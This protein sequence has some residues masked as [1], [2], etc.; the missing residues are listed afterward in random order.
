MSPPTFVVPV[1][2]T[3]EALLKA[4]DTDGDHKITIDDTGP[5]VFVTRPPN[6]RI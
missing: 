2:S 3:L 1:A 5:K 6:D 4:E